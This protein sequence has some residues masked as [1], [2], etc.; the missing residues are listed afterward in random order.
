MGSTPNPLQKKLKNFKKTIDKIQKLCYNK[1]NE[2]KKEVITM[3]RYTQKELR[4]L[5][6]SG[7]A[8]D[9]T[10][11]HDYNAVPK[12]YDVVGY[13]KGIYGCNGK[14]LKDENGRLYAIIGATSA[15]YMF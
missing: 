4:K 2:R 15:L 5:V 1:Y 3:E 6:A 10:N 9:I 11:A 14:L 13:S 12:P 7:V 8:T